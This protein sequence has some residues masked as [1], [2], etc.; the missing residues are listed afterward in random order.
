MASYRFNQDRSGIAHHFLV[1]VMSIAWTTKAHT[2]QAHAGIVTDKAQGQRTSPTCDLFL[3]QSI[4]D[5]GMP[6]KITREPAES[7]EARRQVDAYE[8][9]PFTSS[10]DL[11]K[12]LL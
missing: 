10:E 8:G 3:R 6:F 1:F 4:R 11:M 5:N 9:R 7:I 12:N 2:S